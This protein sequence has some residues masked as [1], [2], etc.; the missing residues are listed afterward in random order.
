MEVVVVGA[1]V[2]GLSVAFFLACA[3]AE[4][5]VVERAGV[6]AGASGVQPGGVRQQWGT[7]ATCLLARESLAF[8]RELGERLGVAA[9]ARLDDCGYLFLAHS[10]EPLAELRAAVAL[11]NELGIASR[12]V[13]TAEAEELVPGLDGASAVGASWCA[14]DGYVDRPQAAVEAFWRAAAER[15]AAMEITEVRRLEPDGSGWRLE[16]ADRSL[17][18]SSVVVA[19]GVESVELVAPLG[20][21]L[22]IVA[23]PRHLF[24]GEPVER[25]LL[26]PLV[27]SAERGLAA[28]QLA[29]GRLLASDLR[30]AGDPERHEAEWRHAVATRLG[31][32]L[33]GL[34]HVRL[35]QRR[36]GLY[37]LTPDRQPVL[38]AVA[39]GLHVAAGF[40]GH[41]FMV[42]PAVGRR[43]AAAV[44]GSAVDD[45]L[46][47]FAPSRFAGGELEEERQLV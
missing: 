15:G 47:A 31:E 41:G 11:Q 33:P 19:A 5:L 4:T 1:G 12:I 14:E 34:A 46:D 38:G 17:T 8:Y 32:L 45:L 18:A 44:L 42:A 7:R 2:T 30:A 13:T 16:L 29:D 21:D 40:S 3:G 43:L 25:R 6:A 26:E 27:V 9:D 36:S 28:K 22:P 23:E 10:D 24:L 20:V 35:P 39:P 37:D